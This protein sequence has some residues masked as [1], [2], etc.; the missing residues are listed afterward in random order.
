MKINHYHAQKAECR[1]GGAECRMQPPCILERSII[2]MLK[3]ITECGAF[4]SAFC[5]VCSQTLIFLWFQNTEQ[6]ARRLP[7]IRGVNTTP[8]DGGE[9]ATRTLVG[10]VI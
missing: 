2:N 4:W 8:Y 9:A 7:P 3:Q 5:A 10:R 1:T 6:N